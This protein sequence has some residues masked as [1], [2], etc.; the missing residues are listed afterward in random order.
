MAGLRSDV[1]ERMDP[2]HSTGEPLILRIVDT[3][4]TLKYHIGPLLS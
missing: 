2:F 1:L 3:L 4:L